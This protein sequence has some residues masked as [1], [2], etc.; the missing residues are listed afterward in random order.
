M[1]HVKKILMAVD[2]SENTPSQMEAG[3]PILEQLGCSMIL[4]HCIPPLSQLPS[5]YIPHE[6]IAFFMEETISTIR[7][8]LEDLYKQ[9]LSH[10][11]VIIETPVGDPIKLINE[12]ATRYN[13]SM[14][15]MGKSCKNPFERFFLGSVASNL[16]SSSSLPILLLG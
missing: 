3:A 13:C 2:L 15:I 10:I 4:I 1:K 16:L 14:V 7:S 5:E 9:Y 11:E 8:Q 6:N 12:Y